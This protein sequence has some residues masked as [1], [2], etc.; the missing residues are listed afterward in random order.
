MG[1]FRPMDRTT[2]GVVWKY[3][4][5]A[6]IVFVCILVRIPR[7]KLTQISRVVASNNA[8]AMLVPQFAP[9]FAAT[10]TLHPGLQ[11]AT[12]W[13]CTLFCNRRVL[14]CLLIFKS[15]N[16]TLSANFP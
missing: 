6:L 14:P 7:I 4:C 9:C 15:Q 1:F 16:F 3:I 10:P 2:T 8:F 12:A 5:V 13:D 11:S